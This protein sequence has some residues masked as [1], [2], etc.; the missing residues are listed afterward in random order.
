VKVTVNKV[1]EA[2]VIISGTIEN[3]AVEAAINTMAVQAG[4]EMKV[5]GFRKGKVPAHIVKKLHGDKLAQDAEGEVLKDLIDAGVKE[6]GINPA[7]ILGQP[8]FKKYDKKEDGIE[9][10]VEVSTRPV[11]EAE[12]HMDVLPSFDRPSASDKEIEE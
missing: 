9:V 1:D 8:T 3:S 5:D 6:A 2:N 4:K 7:Q 12:G 10:E 11:F